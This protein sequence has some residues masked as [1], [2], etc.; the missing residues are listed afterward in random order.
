MKEN[1][2]L[3]LKRFYLGELTIDEE[4]SLIR[5]LLADD[6][7]EDLRAERHAVI[8]LARTEAIEMPAD[9]EHRLKETI[10]DKSVYTNRCYKWMA[11]AAAALLLMGLGF[12]TLF[13]KTELPEPPQTFAKTERK[14]PQP[15]HRQTEETE[16]KQKPATA[17]HQ[18]QKAKLANSHRQSG[19]ASLQSSDGMPDIDISAELADLL[20]NIDQLEQQILVTNPQNEH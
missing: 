8:S 10:K 1:I 18:E 19:Q 9:M 12:W 16:V 13:P 14:V 20:T 11:V 15:E 4:R 6:C 17:P 2:E 3:I 5:M 7:P